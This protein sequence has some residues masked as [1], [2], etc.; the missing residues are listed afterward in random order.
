LQPADHQQV[1]FL[2]FRERV[3]LMSV[4]NEDVYA[5]QVIVLAAILNEGKKTSTDLPLL[6]A[7]Q[8]MRDN[9]AKAKEAVNRAEKG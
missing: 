5:A 9:M 1:D 2:S 3:C 8:K 4:S 6:D 7:A